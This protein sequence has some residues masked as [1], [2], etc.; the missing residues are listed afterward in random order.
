MLLTLICHVN[1]TNFRENV[2]VHYVP[3]S[4]DSMADWLWFYLFYNTAI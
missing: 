2:Y 3:V 1:V 4:A